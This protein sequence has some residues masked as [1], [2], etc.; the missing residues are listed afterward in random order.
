MTNRRKNIV[1]YA[2]AGDAAAIATLLRQGHP[3]DTRDPASL[4]TLLHIAIGRNHLDLVRLLLNHG[5]AIV[6]DGQGRWPSTIAELCEVDP[7]ICDLIADAELQAMQDSGN[8]N[9]EAS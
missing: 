1:D 9:M 8:E 4:H 7:E 5:A 6:T 3:V 2:Y